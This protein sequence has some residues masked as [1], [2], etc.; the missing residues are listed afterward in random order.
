MSPSDAT[1]HSPRRIVSMLL[2]FLAPS[3]DTAV[4]RRARAGTL[5][6]TDAPVRCNGGLAGTRP[7]WIRDT[8]RI[9][10]VWKSDSP[11]FECRLVTLDV[12]EQLFGELLG[13]AA[14]FCVGRS[15]QPLKDV[16]CEREQDRQRVP[17][18]DDTG[19]PSAGHANHRAIRL[20]RPQLQVS[21]SITG[22]AHAGSQCVRLTLTL[23][24][25]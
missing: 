19:E 4:Q 3:N 9:A 13:G 6:A 12:S 20:S 11:N 21:G 15:R 10:R 23:S 8:L 5:R 7:G 18:H 17:L 1:V 24:R 2:T 25:G 16:H 14:E 22:T